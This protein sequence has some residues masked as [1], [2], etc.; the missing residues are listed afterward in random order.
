ME[1]MPV[2]LSPLSQKDKIVWASTKKGI[3]TVGSAYH[4]A[5]ESALA[6]EG[7]FSIKG[8]KERM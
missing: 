7:E 3:F 8:N 2:V 1:Y 5:K 6:D 4:K